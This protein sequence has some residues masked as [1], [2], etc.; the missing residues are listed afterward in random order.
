MIQYFVC[1]ATGTIVCP[2]TCLKFLK[3][4]RILHEEV[5]RSYKSTSIDAY[6]GEWIFKSFVKL[7]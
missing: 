3:K 1:D 5:H 7:T 6:I 2:L 4:L